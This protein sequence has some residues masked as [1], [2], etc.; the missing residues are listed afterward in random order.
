MK[1][2]FNYSV[3]IAAPPQAVFD[4]ISDVAN[5]H[6]TL[7]GM[8]A[9]KDYHGGE[10][11][12]GDMWLVP[13]TLGGEVHDI[14]YEAVEVDAPSLL[15]LTS[16]S[17]YGV[18]LAEWKVTE[19][20]DASHLTLDVSMTMPNGTDAATKKAWSSDYDET[21]RTNMKKIKAAVEGL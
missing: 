20:G 2:S 19:V 9:A 13:Q 6:N 5:L 4:V 18:S 8:G 17:I 10:L 15:E 11:E 3:D 16:T 14:E 12:A 1:L 7:I 21:T